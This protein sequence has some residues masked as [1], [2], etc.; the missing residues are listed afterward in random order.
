M[1]CS[2]KWTD[3]NYPFYEKQPYATR[4]LEQFFSEMN[5]NQPRWYLKSLADMKWK[6]ENEHMLL[7]WTKTFEKAYI[8]RGVVYG[9]NEWEKTVRWNISTIDSIP[10][11]QPAFLIFERGDSAMMKPLMR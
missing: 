8:L 3:T 7:D 9:K 1:S 2:T 10:G 11:W 5:T 4:M 6:N